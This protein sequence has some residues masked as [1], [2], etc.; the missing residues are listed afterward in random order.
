MR[1][2]HVVEDQEHDHDQEQEQLS[3]SRCQVGACEWD[4]IVILYR[5]CEIS[6][7]DSAG[8][9]KTSGNWVEGVQPGGDRPEDR[10]SRERSLEGGRTE[11]LRRCRAL[12]RI[13]RSAR[14][15]PANS[16]GVAMVAS[17]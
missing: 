14:S 2:V 6:R 7:P 4:V 10:Q 9:E 3:A 13:T 17:S 1:R 12:M 16:A 15:G 5:N 8:L 11:C